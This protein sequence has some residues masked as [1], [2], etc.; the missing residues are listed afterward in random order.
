MG[1]SPPRTAP[2]ARP[3]GDRT[4]P[5]QG[6]GG[7]GAG[8]RQRGELFGDPL[9]ESRCA[10]APARPPDHGG[11]RPPRGGALRS[12]GL[13][14]GAPRR[15]A[16]SAS[17]S[18]FATPAPTVA[19]LFDLGVRLREA[20]RALG[21]ALINDRID[22]PWR[23]TP[24][25]CTRRRSV[26]VADARAL[27][28]EHAWIL[29]ACHALPTSCAR[30]AEGADAAVLSPIPFRPARVRPSG[31]TLSLAARAA[32]GERLQL[33]AL[34]GVDAANAADC[35]AA[36]AVAGAAIRADHAAVLLDAPP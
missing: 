8:L 35:F 14:C 22:L 2:S 28:P 23:S 11:R 15:R 10:S 27:L 36:G 3:R 16:G 21:A 26:T 6:E 1:A 18:S 34:G 30:P 5:G 13:S 29:V 25:V 7:G 9:V 19:R 4:G 17:R 24:T 32:V 12:P 31:W 33:V 20:T